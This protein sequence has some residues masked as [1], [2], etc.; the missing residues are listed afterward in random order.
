MAASKRPYQKR[1]NPESEET[2]AWVGFYRRVPHDPA[3]ATEIL[4]Q[5]NADPVLKRQHLAL[6]LCCKE[7]I[8]LNKARMERNKRIGAFVRWLV[9]MLF[10]A[11]LHVLRQTGR[12]SRD[13]AIEI[14]P[15]I[16]KPPR[17]DFTLPAPVGSRS[18]STPGI[19]QRVRNPQSPAPAPAEV[20]STP[21]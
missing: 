13:I 18:T 5:L 3:I 11:P 9:Y 4:T 14:L 20:G 12:G 10:V 21:S 15:E 7:S 8:R 19:R 6:F 1:T 2:K 17:I 16:D